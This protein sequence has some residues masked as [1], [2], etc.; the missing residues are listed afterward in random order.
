MHSDAKVFLFYKT[1]ADWT[2]FWK[3]QTGSPYF[4]PQILIHWTKPVI[5]FLLGP[6]WFVYC[7]LSF[8]PWFHLETDSI[9]ALAFTDKMTKKLNCLQETT[10]TQVFMPQNSLPDPIIHEQPL[11]MAIELCRGRK[12]KQYPTHSHRSEIPINKL[13]SP[14]K[15]KSQPINQAKLTIRNGSKTTSAFNMRRVDGN[16]CL[17]W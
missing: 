13:Q 9:F 7:I 1:I 2:N 4:T 11:F 16:F 15:I 5:V 14:H 6:T 3:L 17:W 8:F 10:G 12:K